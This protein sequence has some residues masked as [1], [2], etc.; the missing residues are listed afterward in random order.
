[1]V[2]SCRTGSEYISRTWIQSPVDSKMQ[3]RKGEKG[4]RG[5]GESEWG[6]R[7]KGG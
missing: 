1:M 6:K 5:K 3:R 4:Q 2:A 7:E